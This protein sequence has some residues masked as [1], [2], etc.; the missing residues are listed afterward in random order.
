MTVFRSKGST[1]YSLAN[2]QLLIACE[3]RTMYISLPPTVPYD[4]LSGKLIT[5]RMSGI[6][7]LVGN[8]QVGLHT[9][10]RTNARFYV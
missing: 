4:D 10:A 9:H 8:T 1:E 6:S 2:R 7:D 5:V 3:G